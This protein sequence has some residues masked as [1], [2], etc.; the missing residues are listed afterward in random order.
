[1]NHKQFRAWGLS[2]SLLF[3]EEE[4]GVL[5]AGKLR[6]YACWISPCRWVIRQRGA[7]K[8][9]SNGFADGRPSSARHHDA[10]LGGSSGTDQGSQPHVRGP[11]WQKVCSGVS[12]NSAGDG[13]LWTDEWNLDAVLSCA[14]LCAVCCEGFYS[15][16]L[17]GRDCFEEKNITESVS[18]FFL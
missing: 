14:L 17:V 6:L 2:A 1:M 12:E 11:W 9:A 3:C 15:G 18:F 5:H 10:Q 7:R 8:R 16:I 4:K 13:Q